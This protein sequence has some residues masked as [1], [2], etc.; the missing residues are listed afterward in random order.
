MKTIILLLCIFLSIQPLAQTKSNKYPLVD[1]KDLAKATSDTV[2]LKAFVMDAYECPPCPPGMICKPCVGDHIMVVEKK[3]VDIL[4][5][6][7]EDRVRI[8]AHQPKRLT[9]GKLYTFT[10]TFRNKKEKFD[11]YELVSFTE[12]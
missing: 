9:I 10:I 1:F 4:K 8:F 3:R 2:Q 7:L 11:N 5:I 6:P 12:R